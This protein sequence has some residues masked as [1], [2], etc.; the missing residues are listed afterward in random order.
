MTSEDLAAAL[1]R[2]HQQIDAGLEGFLAAEA[3]GT[4]QIDPLRQALGALRR[5][6]HLEER[7][8]FPPLR[9]AGM[10]APIFVM[11]R[12][13]GE[14][15]ATM[16]RIEVELGRDPES[17]ALQL[18]CRELLAQ[19]ERHNAKEEAVVYP[20]VELT[21]ETGA[22]AQLRRFMASGEMPPGW[23]CAQAGA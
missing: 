11:L 19:L 5:H 14:I 10:V 9:D 16:D 22:E 7:F 15:W 4:R 1:E 13:H 12:E 2:E 3:A 6:I 23:V 18:Q 17:A 20:Q 21:L 8:M